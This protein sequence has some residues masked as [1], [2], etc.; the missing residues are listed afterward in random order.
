MSLVQTAQKVRMKLAAEQ[1]TLDNRLTAWEAGYD[2]A[3]AEKGMP[4][5]A[6]TAADANISKQK[7][8]EDIISTSNAG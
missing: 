6:K 2:V 7:L 1:T 8:I 3:A 5:L 4:S